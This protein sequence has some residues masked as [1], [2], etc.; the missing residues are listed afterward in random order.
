MSLPI[1]ADNSAM[2]VLKKP[3][4]NITP[5]IKRFVFVDS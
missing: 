4:P 3:Y 1:I 5:V 2:I